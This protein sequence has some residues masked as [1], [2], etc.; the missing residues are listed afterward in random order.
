MKDGLDNMVAAEDGHEALVQTINQCITYAL[1]QL[2]F[3]R[4]WMHRVHHL[5]VISKHRDTDID[6]I[7]IDVGLL[8][9]LERCLRLVGVTRT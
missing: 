2:G 8:D 4:K 1:G 7:C 5:L 3:T 9:V 6:A